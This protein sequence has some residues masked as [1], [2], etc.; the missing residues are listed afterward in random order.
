M[1]KNVFTVPR[2]K[3]FSEALGI[4][5]SSFLLHPLSNM[6]ASLPLR[7]ISYG[8]SKQCIYVIYT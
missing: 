2:M 8:L 3:L 1:S 6:I 5:R 7:L 4:L